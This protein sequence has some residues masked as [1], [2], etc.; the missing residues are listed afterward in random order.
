[1]EKIMENRRIAAVTA[2][3]LLVGSFLAGEAR[4]ALT[5]SIDLLT[6]NDFKFT[7]GGTF[8]ANAIGDQRDWL[9]VKY[10]WTNNFGVSTP[11]LADSLGWQQIQTAP[12][13]VVQDTIKINGITPE[14][15]F[16]SP[17]SFV[18][19]SGNSWGDTI[20]FGTG[21]DILAGMPVS[22][23]L[24]VSGAGLFDN[25]INPA[26]LELLSGFVN[27]PAFDWARRE[28]GAVPEP[29][30]ISL[31]ALAGTALMRRRRA[32]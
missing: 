17:A 10:D 14:N 5:F 26:K 7:I 11:W 3:A 29:A 16:F 1:M 32:S 23:S 27:A 4:A 9:A 15:G 12:W 13:R 6:P 20:Y 2:C 28:A 24:H 21:F 30:T 8:D 19:S 25:T 18:E 31:L 22:G